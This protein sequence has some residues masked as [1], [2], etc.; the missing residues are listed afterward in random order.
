MDSALSFVEQ[1]EI[2]LP[3]FQVSTSSQDFVDAGSLVSFMGDVGKQEREDVLHSTLLAQ[4]AAD[5]KY[6]R[7]K[8]AKDWYNYYV[9]VLSNVGWIL[10]GFEFKRYN[11]STETL[12]ISTAILDVF[13]VAKVNQS[14]VEAVKKTIQLLQSSKNE[15]WWAVFNGCCSDSSN[16]NLQVLPCKV[17][18]SGQVVMNIGSFYFS[19][20]TKEAKWLWCD[21]RSTDISLHWGTQ[22]STLSMEVYNKI[23]D[24][25][26]KKLQNCNKLIG[27][28]NI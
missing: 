6:D 4:L 13:H 10:Q 8:Q 17:D 16:A 21:F 11:S 1:L 5:Y 2:E 15:A 20:K 7:K 27:N 28:L 12:Q 26:I 19:A 24:D 25:V 9:E 3:N 22:T 23:R 18:S 14:E